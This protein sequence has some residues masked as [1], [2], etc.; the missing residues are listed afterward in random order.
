MVIA[1][2]CVLAAGC[3]RAPSEREAAVILPTSKVQEMMWRCSRDAPAPGEG[4]WEPGWADVDALESALPSA[5]AA[6]PAGVVFHKGK[7]L[8]GW[9]RQYVGVVR[10][11]ERFLYGNY[12]P[13]WEVD[14]F[15]AWRAEPVDVCHAGPD[16]FGVEYDVKARRISH[17]DFGIVVLPAFPARDR[18]DWTSKDFALAETQRQEMLRQARTGDGGAAFDLYM[19]YAVGGGDTGR[20]GNLADA[21]EADRWLRV[22]AAGGNEAAKLNLAIETARRDCAAGRPMLLEASERSTMPDG[23]ANAR[24]WLKEYCDGGAAHGVDRS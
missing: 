14:K 22:A 18:A 23:K 1:T 2:T 7:T 12:F 10:N 5:L 17:M 8:K 3:E 20:A 4:T 15:V 21:A 16:Y 24:F 19:H 11:G 6:D 9:R 13:A